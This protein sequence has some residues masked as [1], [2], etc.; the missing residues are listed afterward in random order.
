[1]YEEAIAAHQKLVE[2]APQEKAALGGTYFQAGRRDEALKILAELEEE[3]STP[4]LALDLAVAYS[5]LGKKDEAFRWLN[6]YEH[7]HAFFPWTVKWLTSEL[8]RDDPRSKDLLR[9]LN[10]PDSE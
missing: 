9:R 2:V 5:S 1:M 4:S 8:L 7:P 10:F 3:E 6:Y